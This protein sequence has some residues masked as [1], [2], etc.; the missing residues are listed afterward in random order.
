MRTTTTSR[1]LK[2]DYPSLLMLMAIA[3][4]W[5]FLI[6]GAVFDRLPTKQ[7]KLVEV[8]PAAMIVIAI[9]VVLVTFM[10]GFLA[11][12][13]V[14]DIKRIVE[15]GPEVQRQV[16]EIW[17]I[18]DRGRVEYEYSVDGKSY[19]SGNAIWKNA[20]TSAIQVGDTV[21]LIV[22]RDKPSRAFIA[23]LYAST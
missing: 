6:G 16:T 18:K 4:A 14:S 3:V 19:S 5:A 10:F 12:R 7:G 2:N 17:F 15:S 23:S 21:M 20:E 13:R 1:V 8:G 22:D 9:V 11:W